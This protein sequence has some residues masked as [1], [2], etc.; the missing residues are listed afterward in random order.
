MRLFRNIIF[1]LH[2]AAGCLA[3]VVILTMS[4]TGFLLAFQRQITAQVDTSAVLQSQPSSETPLAIGT[5]LTTL[6][7]S[8]Q[9]APTALVLHNSTK[10]P[11]EAQFGR[12]RTLF[13]NPWTAEIIGQPSEV[14]RAFFGGIQRLHRSLGLGMQS[15]MGRGITGAANLIFLFMLISGMYLW[16]PKVFNLTAIKSRL[17]FRSAAQ[18]RAR[19]WN[20]H[21][22]IGIWTAIPLF[23]IVL[24]GVIISFPWASDLLYTMTGSQ[25]PAGGWQGERGPRGNGNRGAQHGPVSFSRNSAANDF[26]SIDQAIEIAKQQA[27]AW[28]SI[29]V[30]V[31]QPQD[32]VINLSIDAS[33][34][35]QPD[36][37]SQLVVNRQSGKLEAV[38]LFSDNNTGRKLRA[39]ARFLHTGEELGLFGQIVA[40]IACLGAILLVWTGISMAL[41]R[42]MARFEFAR[43]ES[44]ADEESKQVVTT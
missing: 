12:E 19:E 30:T 23:F 26:R 24:T 36:Q 39:W 44:K 4:V 3:G 37:A 16:L 33:H 6:Q 13:L 32:R 20:W 42:A 10:A 38:K 14:L 40:A 25:P 11:A 1:W 28:K 15:S 17:F 9:G 27:P 34:G 43:E 8:G 22:V 41:R 7:N 18:G 31:P 35:G 21:H 5:L 2:L 29:T